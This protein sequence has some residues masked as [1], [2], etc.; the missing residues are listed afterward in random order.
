MS[1]TNIN[2]V[3]RDRDQAVSQLGVAFF[4]VEQLKAEVQSLQNHSIA[5]EELEA[6]NKSLREDNATLKHSVEQLIA[7]QEDDTTMDMT[8]REE[9][10]DREFERRARLDAKQKQL[11]KTTTEKNDTKIS[12][13]SSRSSNG[14]DN[15]S[16]HDITYLSVVDVSPLFEVSSIDTNMVIPQPGKIGKLR[17]TLENERIARKQAPSRRRAPEMDETDTSIQEKTPAEESSQQMQFSRR[18]SFGPSD[19]KEGAQQLITSHE[20]VV[21]KN[22]RNKVDTPIIRTG[23]RFSQ[24]KPEEMT[25][26]WIVNDITLDFSGYESRAPSSPS[27]EAQLP[28]H[29]NLPPT[30]SLLDEHESNNSR[31]EIKAASEIKPASETKATFETNAVPETNA[32]PKSIAVVTNRVPEPALYEDDEDEPTMESVLYEE[33]PTLR[34]S[35][36]PTIALKS[37]MQGL[38]DELSQAKRQFAQYQELYNHQNPALGKRARKSLKEKMEVLLR[39]IDGKAD[40]IYSLHDVLEGQKRQGTNITPEQ[41]QATLQSVGHEMPLDGIMSASKTK[42]SSST[43]RNRGV[44]A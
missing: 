22:A 33:E 37:V 18:F 6:A 14:G 43:S 39:T 28:Y 3:T 19:P 20:P 4:T 5:V 36:S 12:S 16:D 8:Q 15:E 35:Q 2:K 25:S 44:E 13:T 24:T 26:E 10:L 17:K 11:D 27:K 34:P 29:K 32:A 21:N 23:S 41:V 40:Y 7:N 9:A 1:E 38:E 42:T 31:S 30:F